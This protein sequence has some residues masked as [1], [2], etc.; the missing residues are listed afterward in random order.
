MSQPVP[1]NS[2]PVLDY[3]TQWSSKTPYVT[4]ISIIIIVIVCI[5]SFL[6]FDADQYLGNIPLYTILDLE[7]YRILFSPLVGNSVLNLLFI[8]LFFPEMST[9]LEYT[10]GS[11]AYLS[12]ICTLS[13]IINITFII[14]CFILSFMGLSY[15]LLASCS[16]FWTIIFAFITIECMR[17]PDEPRQLFCFPLQISS[18][19]FPLVL[20]VVFCLFSGPVLSFAVSIFVGY[21]QSQGYFDKLRPSSYSLEQLESTGHFF[22]SISRNSGWC[23]VAGLG[24]DSWAPVNQNGADWGNQQTTSL[25]NPM[26]NS[27]ESNKEVSYSYINKQILHYFILYVVPWIW[28]D[29]CKFIEFADSSF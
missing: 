6:I 22:H 13:I 29:S 19:Y 12:L 16:G 15:I 11:L 27:S 14:I 5:F 28:N 25:M 26:R 7:L 23:L 1:S 21:L 24:H 2:N 17:N 4:R 10:M 9:R 18:K 20:Y 8:L 3:Y